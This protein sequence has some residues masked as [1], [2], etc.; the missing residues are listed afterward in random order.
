[1]KL[2]LKTLSLIA[3]LLTI[4]GCSS[5]RPVETADESASLSGAIDREYR[6]GVDDRIQVSVWRN[7]E[8]SLT[9][10]VRPDG[11]I[12]LPLIGDVRAGGQTPEQVA[13]TVR[14]K[15]SAY[16]REPSVAVIVTELRSHE[17][18]SRVRV[19]G[20]VRTPRSLPFRQGMTLLDAVLEAGG[21]NDFAAP[22]RTKLYRKKEGQTNVFDVELD[23]ILRKGRL[24][25]NFALQP[26]DVVTIP[27]RLF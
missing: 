18:L 16:I 9:V 19:T 23:D 17:F 24:E 12:S 2:S 10:P 22:N 21:P 13:A 8:L 1:M 25:T 4:S 7:P 3:I 6:I 20:A 26:G 11:M 14:Q 5:T 15:L 27:E